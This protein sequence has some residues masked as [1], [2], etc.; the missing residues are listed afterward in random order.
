MSETA[1]VSEQR[2][3][4]HRRIQ[5]RVVTEITHMIGLFADG[6]GRLLDVDPGSGLQTIAFRDHLPQAETPWVYAEH[7][8]RESDVARQTEFAAVDL[9]AGRFPADDEALDVVVWNRE[10]VTLKNLIG[11]LEEVHRIL[12]PG[13]LLVIAL[14]NLASLHNR[15][16]L[17]GGVQPTTLHIADGNHVRGFAIRSM[18]RFLREKYGPRLLRGHGGRPAAVCERRRAIAVQRPEPYRNLGAP[19]VTTR[20]AH[21]IPA[22]SRLPRNSES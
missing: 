8:R 16:L 7:D 17:L 19:E 3:R 13:G 21:R 5:A 4:L 12:R 18:T 9:E 20:G 22:V 10:L 11:P 6:R 1:G 15:L 14:P 2:L